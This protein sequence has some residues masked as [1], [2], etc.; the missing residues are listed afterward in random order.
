MKIK[1]RVLQS[2]AQTART[3]KRCVILF[4]TCLALL[5][6]KNHMIYIFVEYNLVI[7]WPIRS[8]VFY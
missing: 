4:F 8:S 3:F 5:D 2:I 6:L 7:P 1:I